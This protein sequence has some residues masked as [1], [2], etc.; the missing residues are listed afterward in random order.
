MV[1]SA[2]GAGLYQQVPEGVW[3]LFQNGSL[4]RSF[5]APDCIHPNQK[6]HSWLSRS[7]W[8]NMVR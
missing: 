1:W 2:P 4:D 5:F 7:L 3:D 8:R 6:F